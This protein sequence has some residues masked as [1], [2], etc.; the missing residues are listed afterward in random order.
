MT[1]AEQLT[2][3]RRIIKYTLWCLSTEPPEA[4]GPFAHYSADQIKMV[5]SLAQELFCNDHWCSNVV[6]KYAVLERSPDLA[7][8][9]ALLVLAP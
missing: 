4:D 9:E 8:F 1:T 3:I 7:E 6:G 5:Q 2:E